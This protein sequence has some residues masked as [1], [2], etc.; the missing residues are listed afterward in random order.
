MAKRNQS[1]TVSIT[2][3]AETVNK[4]L[5]YLQNRKGLPVTF[6]EFVRKHSVTGVENMLYRYRRNATVWEE[7]KALSAQQEKMV[8]MYATLYHAGKVSDKELKSVGLDASM[9]EVE[10]PTLEELDGELP[11]NEPNLEEV[12]RMIEAATEKEGAE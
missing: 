6:D 3:P 5:G 12:D 8:K 4:V 7:K 9:F 2:F 11:G 10:L 1:A